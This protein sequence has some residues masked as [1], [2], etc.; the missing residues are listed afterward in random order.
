MP[1]LLLLVTFALLAVIA[2]AGQDAPTDG[3]AAGPVVEASSS[4]LTS[5]LRSLRGRPL[6]V[7]YWA[8]WCEPCK[9][10]MPRLVEAARRHRGR[11][12]FLGVNVEDDLAAARS[13]AR[14]YRIPFDSLALS[15]AEVQE[16]QDI[17]GLPVTQFY[18][19]DGELAFV[20]QGE[21]KTRDLSDKIDEVLRAERPTDSPS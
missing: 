2:C 10:E 17:L 8:T 4:R 18:R 20:H 21:I 14:S 16:S 19:A 3:A 5:S 6:V 1:R 7:N 15:R 9:E 13:F 12:Q 11:L